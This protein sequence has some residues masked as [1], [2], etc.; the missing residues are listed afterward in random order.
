MSH[1][2]LLILV[3]WQ[4]EWLMGQTDPAFSSVWPKNSGRRCRAPPTI[5]FVS[6]NPRVWHTDGWTDTLLMTKRR[7][8]CC[9]A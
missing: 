1:K 3:F 2:G 5:I 7:L 9:S 8:H 6:H 4:E